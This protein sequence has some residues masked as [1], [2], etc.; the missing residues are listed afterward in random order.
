V[1]GISAGL[2]ISRSRENCSGE[3][4]LK[5]KGIWR[6]NPPEDGAFVNQGIPEEALAEILQLIGKLCAQGDRQEMLEH[7]KGYFC[8]ACGTT[9]FWS[10][11][12]SWAGTDLWTYGKHAAQNA[13]LFIEA[14]FDACETFREKDPDFFAP[15]VNMINDLLAKHR[16]G[17]EIR[18]PRLVLRDETVA[19][20]E[21]AERPSTI[22]DNALD[23]L[24]ASLARS[25]ELLS[26]GRGREAVQESLW[27]LETVAT[28]FR[29]LE[30]S[31]GTIE[32]KYFNQI[33]K[34]LRAGNRGTVLDRVLEWITALHGYLSSPTGGGIRHGLDLAEG[35]AIGENEARLFCNLIRSY[36]SFLLVEHKRIATK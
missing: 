35:I 29:G 20:V 6:F 34:D 17:Y 16:I 15:D 9:H 5:F 33:V 22:A 32:G 4:M 13:P 11:N 19:L 23:I 1:K 27:L 36:V 28:A 14:L 31:T 18:P 21:V 2:S 26:Q 25:D 24:Q 12:A 30:T 3:G 10:S 8:R 7:F